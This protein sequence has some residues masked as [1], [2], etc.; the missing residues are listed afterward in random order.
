MPDG[1]PNNGPPIQQADKLINDL[2][3]RGVALDYSPASLA[4]LEA[5]LSRAP[6]VSRPNETMA[7]LAGAYFGEVIR[8]NLGGQWYEQVPPEGTT[9]LLVNEEHQLMVFPYSILF[10]KLQNGGK[11]LPQLYDE[12]M[13]LTN[14]KVNFQMK[15]SDAP[16]G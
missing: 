10:R 3:A 16:Q 4:Q 1:K 15:Q 9:A 14:L 6:T 11:S 8:R 2:G 7:L 12:V 13:G 5:F